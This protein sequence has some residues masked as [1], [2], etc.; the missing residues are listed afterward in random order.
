VTV[1][2]TL[3][4]RIEV[5]YPILL[6]LGGLVLGFLP[7]LPRVE[8]PPELVFLIFLPPLLYVSAIFTSWRDFRA[9]LRPISLLSIGL[10]IFTT[11]AVAAV[12]HTTIEGLTWAAAFTLGAIVS[13]TDAIA[14]TAVAQRLGVP[15]RIIA[16]I[17]G[18]SLINDATGIVAYRIAVAAVT[19]GVFSLW[20]AGLSFVV[21]AAGGVLFGLAIGWT[22]LWWRRHT[23]QEP[24]IQNTISLL[25]PFAAYLLAEELPTY[26]WE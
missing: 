23:S 4:Y 14:A 11:C 1:L 3:A 21:G 26:L 22:V 9:N 13:P 12:A 25:T 8:L 10:V 16:I 15:R 2:A 20:E 6:V 17:E 19:A 5:P 24:S 18:E 7:K